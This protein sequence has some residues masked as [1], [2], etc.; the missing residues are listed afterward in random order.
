VPGVLLASIT[1]AGR[2]V[3]VHVCWGIVDQHNLAVR[4]AMTAK[5]A[6]LGRKLAHY[7]ISGAEIHNLKILG[8]A[9]S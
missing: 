4:T 8:A 3:R 2:A 7:L 5:P 1:S 9:A 6:F